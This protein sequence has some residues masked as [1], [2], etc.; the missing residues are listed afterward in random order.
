MRARAFRIGPADNY[1]FLA[2][3]ALCL[4]PDPAIAWRVGRIG[5]FRDDAFKPELAGLRVEVCAAAG[6]VIAVLQ[7]PANTGE[8]SA[9]T[10]LALDERQGRK[11]LTVEMQDVEQEVDQPGRVAAI[12]RL[13]DV[14]PSERTPHSSPSR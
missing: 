3:E 1:A 2:I 8:Q 7:R 5:A 14:V 13:N 12:A 11:V 9:K 10:F 4:H 6:V